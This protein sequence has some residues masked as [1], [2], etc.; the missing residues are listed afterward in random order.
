MLLLTLSV[1]QFNQ[2]SPICLFHFFFSLTLTS[3]YRFVSGMICFSL[4]SSFGDSVPFLSLICIVSL[5]VSLHL[6]MHLYIHH[7]RIGFLFKFFIISYDVCLSRTLFTWFALLPVSSLQRGH[8]KTWMR[9][10]SA[11]VKTKWLLGFSWRFRS[12]SIMNNACVSQYV[13]NSTE[14]EPV[15]SWF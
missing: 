6:Y 9:D 14:I 7:Q 13:T 12:L 8:F 10:D 2:F 5:P 3:V 11:L 1:F 15:L 4:S